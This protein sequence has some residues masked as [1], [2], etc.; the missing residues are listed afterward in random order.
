M[1]YLKENIKIINK[2]IDNIDES[3][4]DRLVNDCIQALEKGKKVI[5]SGLGK[6]V[7]ICEKF[8]GTLLSLG[9]NAFFLHTNTALHGDLGAAQDGD[10]VI[11]LTKSG[12]TEE[13]VRLVRCLE[14]RNVTIWLLTFDKRG[15]LSKRLPN[16]LCMSL[17]HEGDQWNIIPNNSTTINLIVLQAVAMQIASRMGLTL[18]DFQRNHPGGHIGEI[19]KEGLAW[20]I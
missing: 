16:V 8:E 12:A 1:N 10:V 6:N 13:S 17:E 4:F 9:L 20:K 14:K 3:T 5:A 19:L 7:P 11:V 2:S 18:E 15:I